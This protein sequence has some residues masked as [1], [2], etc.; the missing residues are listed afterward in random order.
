MKSDCP[1]FYKFSENRSSKIRKTNP[2]LNRPV[3]CEHCRDIVWSYNLST[4]Y[5]LKHKG[6]EC[7]FKISDEERKLLL[8]F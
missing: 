6:I 5:K 8:N 7:T 2:C 3:E 1:Y 4:H